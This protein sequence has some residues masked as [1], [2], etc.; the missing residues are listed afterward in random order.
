MSD[1]QQNK[2]NAIALYE[3][4]FN[5]NKPREA[6]ERYAGDYYRKAYAG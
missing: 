6:Q 1:R 2:R 4:A 5:D 3:L